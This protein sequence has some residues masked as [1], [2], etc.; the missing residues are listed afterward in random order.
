MFV[1]HTVA[2][3]SRQTC[4]L[5]QNVTQN[6]E[7]VF[8]PRWASPTQ[9]ATDL[10]Q[11]MV[12]PAGLALPCYE[13]PG[14]ELVVVEQADD[15]YHHHCHDHDDDDDLN[16]LQFSCNRHRKG[17]MGVRIKTYESA[18]PNNKQS[19]WRTSGRERNDSSVDRLMKTLQVYN[20]SDLRSKEIYFTLMKRLISFWNHK[21]ENN[22]WYIYIK[23]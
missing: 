8:A 21:L 9:S 18:G 17:E 11:G 13:R 3:L 7:L 1:L 6:K 12:V 14:G 23:Y 5:Y 2:Q 22:I 10:L 15:H 4:S 16:K 19:V 20:T